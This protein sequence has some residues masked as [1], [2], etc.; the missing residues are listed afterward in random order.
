VYGLIF[1]KVE[2]LTHL[3]H[4]LELRDSKLGWEITL[5][6]LNFSLFSPVQI[7]R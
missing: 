1:K 5:T 6:Y 4:I 7:P 3:L 2:R